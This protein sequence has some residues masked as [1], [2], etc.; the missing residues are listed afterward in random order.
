MRDADRK[1]SLQANPDKAILR[2]ARVLAR[3]AA[4]EDHERE[5]ANR[6]DKEESDDLCSNS[7]PIFKMSVQ[8]K[9][10]FYFVNTMP[11]AKA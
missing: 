1:L 4:R 10:S 9:I 3:L 2:I 6:R 8:L 11:S 5:L 7:Q